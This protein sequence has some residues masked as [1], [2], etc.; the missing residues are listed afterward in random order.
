[1]CALVA[2][3]QLRSGLG[4]RRSKSDV[5]VQS[6]PLRVESC[7]DSKVNLVS[8]VAEPSIFAAEDR[9]YVL[10]PTDQKEKSS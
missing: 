1:M 10:R 3:H 6:S 2:S 5:R 7:T 8:A 9:D 4:Q